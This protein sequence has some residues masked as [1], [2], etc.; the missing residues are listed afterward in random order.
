M[1][2]AED[3][4]AEL[5]TGA[6]EGERGVGVQAF[7]AAST[8]R[9]SD[10]SRQLRPQSPLLPGGSLEAGAQRRIRANGVRPALDAPGRLQAGNGRDEVWAGDVERGRKGRTGRVV[11]PLLGHGRPAV[12]TADDYAPERA[13]RATELSR[14]DGLIVH[15]A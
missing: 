6:G 7:E 5:V 3:P 13:R 12:G 15:A 8:D 14:D 11:R 9:A 2:L 1:Q 10:P 4:L